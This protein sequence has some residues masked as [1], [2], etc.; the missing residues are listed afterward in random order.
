MSLEKVDPLTSWLFLGSQEGNVYKK[1]AKSHFKT[2]EPTAEQIEI[3]IAKKLYWPIMH[4]V[5]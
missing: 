4:R 3:E 1:I 2:E 5:F